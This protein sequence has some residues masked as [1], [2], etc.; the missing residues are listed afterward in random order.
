M[1]P[2]NFVASSRHIR[3]AILLGVLV[4]FGS[5]AADYLEPV[6]GQP[7][8]ERFSLIDLDGHLHQLKDYEGKVVIVSFWA[9]WCPEC[10]WEMPSLQ[11][12]WET[13]RDSQ[14][15]ILAINVG[16]ERREVQSFVE[17]DK[18]TFP[19]LLDYDLGTY[20][21]WPVLGIPTSFLIDRQG[22]IIHS[23][24]GAIDWT[25]P[26]TLSKIQDLLAE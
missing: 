7:R 22:R 4:C 24:V 21:E 11:T 16:E 19:V 14:F 8:A 12:V 13:L 17:R 18:L 20:K 9:S 26:E 1:G 3:W 6:A 23:V 10:I 25:K 2:I 5:L 15:V